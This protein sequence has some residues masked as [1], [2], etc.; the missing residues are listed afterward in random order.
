MSSFN[1]YEAIARSH[2]D[3]YPGGPYI[4][5]ADV[6]QELQRL[7]EIYG[8]FKNLQGYSQALEQ[9]FCSFCRRNYNQ[10]QGLIGGPGGICI[11]YGCVARCHEIIDEVREVARG[12]DG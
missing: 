11:C 8:K 4:T 6:R 3:A 10:V 1:M 12:T 9:I 5:S 2:N 7:I